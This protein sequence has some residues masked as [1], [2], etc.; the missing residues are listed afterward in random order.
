MRLKM[1]PE[2]FTEIV[3]FG[4]LQLLCELNTINHSKMSYVSQSLLSQ[5]AE[6]QD[7]S[8]DGHPLQ[9]AVHSYKHTQTE[10]TLNNESST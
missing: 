4:N 6:G 7:D 2:V 8:D 9:H 3:R 10:K 1:K 5:R